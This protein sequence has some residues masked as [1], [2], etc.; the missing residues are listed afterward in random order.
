MSENK[1]S[2]V[3]R[4]CGVYIE[5]VKTTKGKW[6]PVDP[7]LVTVVTKDGDTVRG[8]IPHWSTCPKAAAFK[9][10]RDNACSNCGEPI[11]K[12][13]LA[14]CDDCESNQIIGDKFGV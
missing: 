2:E 1:K 4:G 6:M 11:D 8:Y 12:V 10:K 9:T 7:A 14:Y 3:C 5:W 13:G